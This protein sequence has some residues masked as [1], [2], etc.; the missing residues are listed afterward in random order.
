MSSDRAG[1][2]IAGWRGLHV[3]RT[4]KP[5][6]GPRNDT[7]I[8]LAKVSDRTPSSMDFSPLDGRLSP[9]DLL[10]SNKISSNGP[11]ECNL[12]LSSNPVRP[13]VEVCG[14]RDFEWDD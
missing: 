3:E 5:H 12:K 8:V 2:W 7:P 11:R 9:L 10:V 4:R 13:I 14:R 1:V 6:E